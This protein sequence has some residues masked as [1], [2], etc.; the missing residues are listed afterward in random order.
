[1][2]RACTNLSGTKADE[3]FRPRRH[4]GSAGPPT[5]RR[6]ASGTVGDESQFFCISLRNQ[7]YCIQVGYMVDPMTRLAGR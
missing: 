4:S 1:M 5:L 6:A 2:L 7:Y 3:L